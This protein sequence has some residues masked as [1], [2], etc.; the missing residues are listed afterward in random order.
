MENVH[1]L[2]CD[3]GEALRGVIALHAAAPWRKGMSS[4]ELG[5]FEK[6]LG[7]VIQS[8]YV[9]PGRSKN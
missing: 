1:T 2:S 3:A 9:A 8:Q 5:R 4:F 7:D 6:L